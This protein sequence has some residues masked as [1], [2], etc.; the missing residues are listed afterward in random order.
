[1]S[2]NTVRIDICVHEHES[3]D[4]CD[5]YLHLKLNIYSVTDFPFFSFIFR[6][7]PK[8]TFYFVYTSLYNHAVHNRSQILKKYRASAFKFTY[9]RFAKLENHITLVSGGHT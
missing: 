2:G 6:K 3:G 4:K 8:K 5:N 9:M 1:M 7:F